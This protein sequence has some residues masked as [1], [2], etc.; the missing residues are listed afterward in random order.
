MGKWDIRGD[1]SSFW[2]RAQQFYESSDPSQF[3]CWVGTKNGESLLGGG[4]PSLESPTIY[5]IPLVR[6]QPNGPTDRKDGWECDL[7]VL[8][9]RKLVL[10]T[11]SQSLTQITQCFSLLFSPIPDLC[12]TSVTSNANDFLKESLCRLSHPERVSLAGS[13]EAKAPPPSSNSQF[14][15]NVKKS[16]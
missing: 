7:P 5:H 16:N 11:T 9:R 15:R 10:Q 12:C 6:T 2:L 13:K 14:S 4:G 3:R 1:S 8:G